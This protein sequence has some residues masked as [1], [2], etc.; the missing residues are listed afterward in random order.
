MYSD[1]EDR[2]DIHCIHEE[3]VR[4]VRANMIDDDTNLSLAELFKIMGDATR[5]KLIFALMQKELCVCDL[6][7][8]SGAS[9]SAVSHQLRVLRIHKLV[10]YR[11]EGKILYYSL[12]DEHVR[13]LFNQGLEHIN[14]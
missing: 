3:K 13:T 4:G 8:V 6:A 1:W 5:L 9:D 12:R 7:A 10:K 2:C 14:E 11:R